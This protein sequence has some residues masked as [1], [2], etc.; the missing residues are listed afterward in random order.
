VG[1]GHVEQ[2]RRLACSTPL[3]GVDPRRLIQGSAESWRENWRKKDANLPICRE[4][5]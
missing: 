1:V 2:A 4:K 3:R 5:E